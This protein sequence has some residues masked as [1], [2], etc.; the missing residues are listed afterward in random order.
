MYKPFDPELYGRDD[1]AKLIV[2]AWLAENGIEARVNPDQYGIDLLAEGPK[3]SYQIE[4]EVKHNWLG[5]DF[6]FSTVHFSGR[7]TKFV[8][9]DPHCLFVMLSDSLTK[10]LVVSGQVLSSARK[11]TKQ[12]IYTQAEQF[13]EVDLKDCWVGSISDALGE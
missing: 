8:V 9:D 1:S 6:P 11:V 2:I 13:L 3:G 7:K 12:T 5:G 4:V 10:A